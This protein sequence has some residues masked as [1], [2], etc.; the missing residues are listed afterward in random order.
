MSLKT[1]LDRHLILAVAGLLA[2]DPDEPA[3]A[4]TCPVEQVT[5]MAAPG[6]D[7]NLEAGSRVSFSAF[8]DRLLYTFDAYDD[9]DRSYFL[10]DRCGGVPERFSLLDGP[11]SRFTG[12]ETDAGWVLYAERDERYFVLDRLDV[13]GFDEP[14][15]VLGLPDIRLHGWGDARRLIFTSDSEGLSNLSGV[16]GL[17]GRTYEMYIHHGDPDVPAVELGKTIVNPQYADDHILVL[18]DDGS[19]RR[20]DDRIG[21]SA[22]L[23]G[24]VRRH[25]FHAATRRLIWQQI[26]DDISEPV[27]LRDLAGGEDLPIA[28]NT[29]AQLSWNRLELPDQ[30]ATGN[31]LFN[32]SG[33]H[34]ALFGPE[35]FVAAVVR[36]A[37]GAAV[38]PPADSRLLGAP[39][40]EFSLLFDDGDEAALARWNPDVG[41]LREWYRGPSGAPLPVAFALEDDFI[42]Y[43]VLDPDGNAGTL[44]RFDHR[45]GQATL[46]AP[47][48]GPAIRLDD[49]RYLTFL[50]TSKYYRPADIVLFDPDSGLYTTLA[51]DIDNYHYFPDQGLIYAVSR[52]DAPGLYA[53]PIPS[54]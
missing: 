3:P 41:A 51:K 9:P 53:A 31:W 17:G 22:L 28:V 13:P 12:I 50:S 44:W 36:T 23:L 24:G 38:E 5:R 27:F 48:M 18:S 40:D 29:F 52:S 34:A 10:L 2:C 33:S 16:A 45:T 49:D 25:W 54:K 32:A 37:D 11:A 20:V 47:R 43:L 30:G 15:P 35:R 14:R 1:C 42:D 8:G 46:I 21:E 26:G 6:R 7:W 4:S 19:L 39:A